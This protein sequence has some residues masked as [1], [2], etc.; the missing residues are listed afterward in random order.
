MTTNATTPRSTEAIQSL[1]R[2]TLHDF[3]VGPHYRGY[4][5]VTL[6]ITLALEDETRLS[7]IVK[8]I[9]MPV[10]RV[11]GCSWVAVERN[12]RTV[13]RMCWKNNRPLLEKLAGTQLPAPPKVSAFLSILFYYLIFSA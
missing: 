5:P 12:M 7:A 3:G 13:A 1:L 11:I 9:Y 4:R 6:A 10:S 2:Q 8:E